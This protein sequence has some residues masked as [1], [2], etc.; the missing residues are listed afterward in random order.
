MDLDVGIY[1]KASEIKAFTLLDFLT[2]SFSPS[3]S[4]L[5]TL[6]FNVS[7]SREVATGQGENHRIES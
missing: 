7:S 3:S 1:L 6:H 2:Y 4:A 5:C